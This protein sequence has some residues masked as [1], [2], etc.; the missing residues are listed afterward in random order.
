MRKPELKKYKELDL[1]YNKKF[2][3]Y[4]YYD[5]N[6]FKRDSIDSKYN[7]LVNFHRDLD[8]FNIIEPRKEST[9]QKKIRVK[10]NSEKLYNKLL[11]IYFNQD[12]NL[13]FSKI[14]K[15]GPKYDLKNLLINDYDYD[16]S[17]EEPADTELADTAL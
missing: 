14:K 16:V 3:F 12:H 5:I 11:Q 4:K 8:K 2:S 6:S 7:E 17:Y 15:F 10:N 9:K 13:S 1:V